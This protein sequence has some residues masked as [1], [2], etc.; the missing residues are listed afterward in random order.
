MQKL[1][2]RFLPCLIEIYKM[3]VFESSQIYQIKKL[4]K[5][6]HIP[7]EPW[8]YLN[9]KTIYEQYKFLCT[10]SFGYNISLIAEINK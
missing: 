9:F 4:S 2:S 6:K 5:N 10:L 8:V 7:S 3:A 1:K